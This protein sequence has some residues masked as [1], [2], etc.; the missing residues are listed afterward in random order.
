MDGEI[1]P[2]ISA[3]INEY[4]P[5][6]V[7]AVDHSYTLPDPI[8]TMKRRYQS[9]WKS[10]PTSSSFNLVSPRPSSRAQQLIIEQTTY[11]GTLCM[12]IAAA[13][14]SLTGSSDM[15]EA[16]SAATICGEVGSL[17]AM[18]ALFYGRRQGRGDPIFSTLTSVCAVIGTICMVVA[19]QKLLTTVLVSAVYIS[20]TGGAIVL[21]SKASE[22]QQCWF[23]AGE[24]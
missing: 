9:F 13:T 17:F 19:T 3:H 8:T 14:L 16:I 15:T 2:R 21:R 12:T 6:R 23:G 22:S 11:S 5:E 4:D 1:N 10:H 18:T 20:V 7:P 24:D